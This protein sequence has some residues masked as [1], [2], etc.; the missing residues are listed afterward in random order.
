MELYFSFVE[1]FFSCPPFFCHFHSFVE[2]IKRKN[3]VFKMR[4]SL[5]LQRTVSMRDVKVAQMKILKT[6]ITSPT[7]TWR[8]MNQVNPVIQTVVIQVI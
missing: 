5:S 2:W 4:W 8:V 3:I 6:L 7:K 1:A